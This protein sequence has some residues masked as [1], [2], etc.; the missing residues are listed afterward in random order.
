MSLYLGLDSSTQSLSAVAIEIRGDS[1]RVV[2]Q[3]ALNFDAALPAYHTRHGVLRDDDPSVAVSPPL[4][5]VEALD[6]MMG[7]FAKSG[8]DRTALAAIAGSA[9]QHGSVYLNAE[10][11]SRLASLNPSQPL[12]S[13]LDGILARPVAP[14]WMDSSTSAE[15]REIAG[16][17][18]GAMTLARLTGSRAFERFTGAQIRRWSKTSPAGYAATDRVHL[19]SSFLAS[20]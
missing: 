4:M 15:C 18:G 10:A 3:H 1:R 8:L 6:L 12:V 11:S 5:W 7:A 17:M 19:V 9:Q 16:A 20:L 14:I 2:W 13:Q